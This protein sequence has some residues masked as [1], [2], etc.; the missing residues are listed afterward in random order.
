MPEGA[1]SL[2][3]TALIEARGLALTARGQR[4]LGP[5]DLAIPTGQT[6]V[7]LG[8]NGAGKSLALRLLHGLLRPSEGQV[9]WEGRPLDRA[10]RRRQAMVFQRPVMLRRSVR[11]NLAF[12]LGALGVPRAERRARLDEA[13]ATAGLTERA[14]QPARLLS[15][16]EQ[17]R[18]A[19]ARALAGRPAALLLDEPTASLDPAATQA[20]EAQLT[21][22][23][24][25][26]VT[27]VLVTHDMGQA[28]RMADRI[29]FLHAGRLAETGPA[30]Q[31]DA[32][33]SAPLAAWT[34]GRLY[35]DP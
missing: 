7:I 13:L 6:T 1:H 35:L 28:R 27:V 23:R 21:A 15:G 8:A 4:L 24:A 18:L 10:A 30:A 12:A 26:G 16:G 25:R 9:L 22:A 33:R 2:S 29:A 3:S 31:L 20:I 17:Q 11:G 14:A 34:E 19:V 32:P 5:L